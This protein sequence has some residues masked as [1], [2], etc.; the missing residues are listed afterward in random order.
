MLS[1]LGRTREAVEQLEAACRLE[2]REAE[3]R[4]KLGLAW[5]ELGDLNRTIAALEQA[6]KLAPR[7]ARALYNLGLAYSERGDTEQAVVIVVHP[8]EIEPHDR[9]GERLERRQVEKQ[10]AAKGLHAEAAGELPI[11][12]P[13]IVAADITHDVGLDFG[14]HRID[15]NLCVLHAGQQPPRF[16]VV[17]RVDGLKDRVVAGGGQ[18]SC[19]N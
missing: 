2:P 5:N 8:V 16:I 11:V 12:V 10:R 4:F 6:V 7:H 19:R 1:M 17:E 15:E 14:K 18:G 9:L 3:Y 13:L